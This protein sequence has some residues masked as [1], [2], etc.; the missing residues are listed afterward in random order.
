MKICKTIKS[1]KQLCYPKNSSSNFIEITIWHGCPPLNLAHIFRALFPRNTSGRLLLS[2]RMKIKKK[3]NH[4]YACFRRMFLTP[5]LKNVK[6]QAAATQKY[7][8]IKNFTK[9]S[10]SVKLSCSF[11][12][13]SLGVVRATKLY[14]Q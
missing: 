3:K 5:S 14:F 11:S 1:K 4:K 9:S 7:P 6:H 12:E 2:V 13:H 10:C 8:G